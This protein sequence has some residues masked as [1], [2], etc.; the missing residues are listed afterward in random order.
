MPLVTLKEY[1]GESTVRKE[2]W[3][4]LIQIVDSL[5]RIKAVDGIIF[6]DDIINQI[7]IDSLIAEKNKAVLE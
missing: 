4:S 3:V 6:W 5:K 1:I 7:F 2:K